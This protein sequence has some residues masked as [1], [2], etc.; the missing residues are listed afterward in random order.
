MVD[1]KPLL[2]ILVVGF[3]HK[4][5]CQ[6]E[7]SYPELASSAWKYLST[8]A[9]PDG[10]H[11]YGKDT[12]YFNL[13]SLSTP[14]ESIFGVS[15]YRQI[16]VEVR[17]IPISNQTPTQEND[18]HSSSS[19]QKLKNKTSDV[20]RST[21]Q[22]G[23]TALCSVP[24]YGY[25]EVKLSLIAD[26][27]F[28]QGDFE[29]TEILRNAYDQLNACLLDNQSQ[30]QRVPGL[31]PV[32]S[33][34]ELSLS[35]NI[36]HI[37]LPLRDLILRW[38]QKV[39]ILFKLLLLQRRIV[40]F[41]SPV[42]PMCE[43]ILSIASL[44]PL[45]LE[46]GF[47]QVACVRTSRPMSPMPDFPSPAGEAKSIYREEQEQEEQQEEKKNDSPESSP[48]EEKEENSPKSNNSPD[49][50]Y[51]RGFS[52]ETSVDA[53]AATLTPLCSVAP[54][55]WGAPLAIFEGGSLCLP[56]L[57]LPY[58]DLL[59]DPSVTGYFIGTSN[60]L[61]QQKRNLADI[62]IEIESMQMDI[63]DADLRRQ[64]QL[65]TEDLRFFD[66]I[67]R[68]V[69]MRKDGAEG[70]DQWVREQ[71]QGYV[72]ALLK[73]SLVV[74]VPG[75]GNGQQKELDNFNGFFMS[76][77]KRTNCYVDWLEANREFPQRLAHVP[78]GHPF[79]GTMSVQDVKLKFAK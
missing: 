12:V 41:G 36:F 52:R 51:L 71:F 29:S 27:F 75:E 7:F 60:I 68:H 10:S 67:L 77:F 59:T 4:K 35:R 16:P 9:L 50:K 34:Q 14:N 6:V 64:M 21:V 72:L 43:F 54:S 53:L 79:A 26:C 37:G 18:S 57:S 3:H 42:R 30:Y 17:N 1:E 47:K 13:P 39:M 69:Q 74:V 23:V 20:T 28:N 44:H 46:S 15:C 40:C 62:L 32:E 76:Q 49:S 25:I 48:E 73:T 63:V 8:L 56:Y 61:F 38:R 24:I 5:G 2:H 65:T 31:S 70:S 78:T 11:N 19:F 33:L 45:L 66:H 58:L 22:K 55:E